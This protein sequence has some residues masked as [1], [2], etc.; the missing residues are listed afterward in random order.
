MGVRTLL[1]VNQR[2]LYEHLKQEIREYI[3]KGVEAFEC[4]ANDMLMIRD[5]KLYREEYDTFEEFCRET[6]GRSKTHVNRMIQAGDVIRGLMAAG[7]VVLPD[8]ERIARELALYPKRDRQLIWQRARQI[9][10]RNNEKPNYQTIR[11]A[12][13]EIVPSDKTKERWTKDLLRRLQTARRALKMSP[14]FSI[15][16]LDSML[17]IVAQF[18]LIRH[19]LD[20]IQMLAENRAAQLQREHKR[21]QNL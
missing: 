16:G 18:V 15:L 6:L 19:A 11:D 17:D 14:D 7:E 8:N 5:Q 2:Q 10:D 1:T 4:V 3:Q 9:A 12:A 21:K 13:L 20:E